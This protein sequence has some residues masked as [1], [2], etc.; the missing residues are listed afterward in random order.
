MRLAPVW[1]SV[2]LALPLRDGEADGHMRCR[3]V[4]VGKRKDVQIEFANLLIL[5]GADVSIMA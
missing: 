4:L 2:A 3:S 1:I 5:P